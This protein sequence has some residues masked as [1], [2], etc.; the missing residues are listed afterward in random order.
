MLN[1]NNSPT[2]GPATKVKGFYRITT[3]K[4]LF[5][6]VVGFLATADIGVKTISKGKM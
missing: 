3:E 5:N 1:K 4:Q 2:K 6:A